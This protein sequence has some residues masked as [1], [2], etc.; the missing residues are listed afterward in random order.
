MT[1]LC[2]LKC[3][4]PFCVYVAGTSECWCTR[5]QFD[6]KDSTT[7][8]EKHFM[9]FVSVFITLCN[10]CAARE[11]GHTSKMTSVPLSLFIASV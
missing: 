4:F 3:I 8:F 7:F 5:S 10:F 6:G 11:L 9:G 2:F 1:S